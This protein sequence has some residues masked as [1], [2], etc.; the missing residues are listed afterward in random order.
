MSDSCWR[1]GSSGVLRSVVSNPVSSRDLH[2]GWPVALVGPGPCRL[3]VFPL[4]Q[5]KA[6]EGS[7]RLPTG[8]T[9]G[10]SASHPHQTAVAGGEAT[11][12]GCQPREG[13]QCSGPP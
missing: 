7:G 6:P 3:S 1:G 5:K 9:R 2:A 11:E 12:G 4:Q 10:G 13:R 8:K